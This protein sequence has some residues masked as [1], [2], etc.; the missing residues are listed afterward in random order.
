MFISLRYFF[1]VESDLELSKQSNKVLK[2]GLI[3]RGSTIHTKL[4][5]T[6]SKN[7][8]ISP[9]FYNNKIAALAIVTEA[10]TAILIS[11]PV[12]MTQ[13]LQAAL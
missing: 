8:I 7:K 9:K 2:S 1:T 3:S 12:A 4:A 13:C 6:T 10:M 5:I 11:D